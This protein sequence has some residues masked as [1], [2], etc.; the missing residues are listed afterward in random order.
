MR[1][2][3][4]AFD[5]ESKRIVG[6]A[7][8]AFIVANAAAQQA[9]TRK[10]ELQQV[11][12]DAEAK[13]H[14]LRAM[15]RNAARVDLAKADAAAAEAV[16]R[17]AQEAEAARRDAVRTAQQRRA[18]Q[19]WNDS[20]AQTAAA[21]AAAA[22]AH[23]EAQAAVRASD[24]ANAAPRVAA[25][26]ALLDEKRA[27]AAEALISAQ[28]EE[29]ALK[30]R[31]DAIRQQASYADT[32]SNIPRDTARLQSHTTASH[33]AAEM[34]TAHAAYIQAT[35]AA[36][37]KER[38]LAAE[39]AEAEAQEGGVDAPI[40]GVGSNNET[41]AAA[42]QGRLTRRMAEWRNA[43]KGHFAMEREG[44]SDSRVFSDV[45]S[46]L[47]YALH[48]AGLTGTDYAGQVLRQAAR[49]VPRAMAT[50]HNFQ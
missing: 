18:V 21:A 38:Q 49:P 20:Q 25:R 3:K 13:R 32:I 36:Y 1:D 5:R 12:G 2:A 11:L 31:L 41:M 42:R 26:A 9:E 6:E 4:Q 45:R 46:K 29:E 43:E 14:K 8:A 47:A 48:A 37:E 50:Q 22:A 16:L 28:N 19:E 24:V 35:S 15:Q 7:G 40:T 44:L 30:A 34:G 17:G 23:D 33:F 10:V 39:A 27:E